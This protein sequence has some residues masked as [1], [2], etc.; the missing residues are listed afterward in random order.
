MFEQRGFEYGVYHLI[1][2]SSGPI[3]AVASSH[4]NLELENVLGLLSSGAI[5]LAN[6]RVFHD[7]EIPI[8][9]YLRVHTRPRRFPVQNLD[10]KSRV[11][12]E[13]DDFLILN[14]PEGIPCHPTVDNYFENC[15]IA[16][17]ES[18]KTELHLTHRLDV[19]TKGLLLFAKNKKFQSYFNQLLQS[20]L[21]SKIYRAQVVGKCELRG[22]FIHWMEPSPRAP[23]NVSA[24]FHEGWHECRL[25]ILSGKPVENK[26]GESTELQIELM[27]GRTHQI[28]SQMSALGHPVVGDNIYGNLATDKKEELQ[29]FAAHLEF[30]FPNIDSEKIS[31]TL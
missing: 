3:S 4:L 12:S 14:K 18:L 23:K 25:K 22:E 10:W 2:E 7:L 24:A 11:V 26:D 17:S 5:Y 13:S 20:G 9:S 21:V 16:A 29:L 30:P 15:L 6:K 28:R 8:G 31:F 1:T 27:T 19:P